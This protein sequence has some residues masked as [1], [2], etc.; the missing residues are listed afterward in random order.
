MIKIIITAVGAI[1]IFFSRIPEFIKDGK[2]WFYRRKLRT[3]QINAQ[4]YRLKLI[5]DK[6]K[7][8]VHKQ[9]NEKTSSDITDHFSSGKF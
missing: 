3:S 2:L 4:K 8:K 7:E 5:K 6:H 9:A 1:F